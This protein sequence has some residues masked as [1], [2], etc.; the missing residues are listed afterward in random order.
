MWLGWACPRIAT[1]V[2]AVKI[3]VDTNPPSGAAARTRLVRR[4]VSLGLWHH[5]RA[6]LLAGKVH[7]ILRRP[8]AKGRDVYDLACIQN[9]V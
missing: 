8:F 7:A 1:R 2:L 6:S 4:H 9:S 5:D 3:D